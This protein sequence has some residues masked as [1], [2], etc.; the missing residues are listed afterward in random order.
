MPPIATTSLAFMHYIVLS[1]G[2]RFES[3]ETMGEMF[4]AFS[5]K[6]LE[7]TLFQRIWALMEG[8]YI[9]ILAALVVDWEVFIKQVITNPELKNLL[10]DCSL[11]F[12]S[13]NDHPKTKLSV[14]QLRNLRC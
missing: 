5:D 2:K 1:L 13:S 7:Q 4:R 11:I 14:L 10:D 8:I 6:L 9:N 3:Y 12:Y